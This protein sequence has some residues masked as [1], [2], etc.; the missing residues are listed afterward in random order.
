MTIK[1]YK[2]ISGRTINVEGTP[3]EPD[4]IFKADNTI[5]EIK[6]LVKSLKYIEE[7]KE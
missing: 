6:N 3:R 7:V 2:N 5:R 4:E 1:K